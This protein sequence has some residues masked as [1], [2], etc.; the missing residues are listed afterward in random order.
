MRSKMTG[1][2]LAGGQNNRMG[3]NKALLRID[4][5][6]IIERIVEVVNPIFSEVLL[7]TNSPSDFKSLGSKSVG[8]VVSTRGS[9]AGIYSGLVH[10]ETYHSFFF[11]CDM[12]FIRPDLVRFMIGQSRGCDVIIP[13]GKDGLEPLHAIYSKDCIPPIESQLQQG[14][15]KIL[16]F[17]PRVRV[18][19]IEETAITRF[20]PDQIGFFNINTKDDYERALRIG[21]K[22]CGAK[23]K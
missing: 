21:E 11:A 23:Q 8:D 16:D 19:M 2:I 9:L 1:I 6:T 5:K 10:S 4:G 12:A 14:D 15:L 17:F 18:R 3:L 13:G 22:H 20:D 7:V